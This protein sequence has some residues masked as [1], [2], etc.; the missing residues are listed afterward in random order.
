[1]RTYDEL[2]TIIGW[3]YSEDDMPEGYDLDIDATARNAWRDMAKRGV[4]DRIKAMPEEWER[5][6]SLHLAALEYLDEPWLVLRKES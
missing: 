5:F 2:K 4:L 1:M 6:E 3:D